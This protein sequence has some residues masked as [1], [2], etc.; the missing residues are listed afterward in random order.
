MYTREPIEIPRIPKLDKETFYTQYFKTKTPVI[1]TDTIKQWPAVEKWTPNYLKSLAPDKL[2]YVEEGNV[3]QE[4]TAFHQIRL[5]EYID[6]IFNAEQKPQ[7]RPIY[8]A[9]FNIFGLSDS[10]MSDVDFSLIKSLTLHTRTNG[11]VGPKGTIASFHIDWADNLYAQI[12]GRKHIKLVSPE[13]TPNMYPNKKYDAGTLASSVDA[14]NYDAERY[15][16]FKQAQIHYTTLAP[17]ELLYIPY[18]WW[19]YLKSLDPSISINCFGWT[20]K[21]MCVD[22][23]VKKLK[24]LLHRFNLYG[25]HDCTCHMIQDGKR[26]VRPMHY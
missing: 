10:L 2:F 14:D 3:F 6:G 4:T 13:F 11:W 18:G 19:H 23:Q 17:G 20:L 22:L 21:G 12:Y 5:D 24:K 25:R 16:L 8:L 9:D 26:V 1:L 7:Q 15:P